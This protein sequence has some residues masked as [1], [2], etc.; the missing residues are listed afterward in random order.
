LSPG[1]RPRRPESL[2]RPFKFILTD[3]KPEAVYCKENNGQR[4]GFIVLE[5]QDASQVPAIGEPWFLAFNASIEIHPVMY[6]ETLLIEWNYSPGVRCDAGKR[7][8]GSSSPTCRALGSRIAVPESRPERMIA[9]P[10]G[11]QRPASMPDGWL[12]SSRDPRQVVLGE[13][14]RSSWLT[15]AIGDPPAT[16]RATRSVTGL[17]DD[18][19]QGPRR[20]GCP[21]AGRVRNPTRGL[22]GIRRARAAPESRGYLQRT[23]ESGH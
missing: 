21:P 17:K 5:M 7:S 12:F 22:G 23:S 11:Q 14:T 4:A 20:W 8:G 16:S 6:C 13:P 18:P 10:L 19:L 3:L 9:S 1:T 2:A 15:S